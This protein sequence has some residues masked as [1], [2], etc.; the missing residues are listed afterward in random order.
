MIITT[1]LCVDISGMLRLYKRKGSLEGV[2][3]DPET[4]RTLSDAEARQYLQ[5]CLAKGW[6]VLPMGDCDNF[7]HQTGCKG[8][9]KE[10]E[11]N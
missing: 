4:G 1:H 6:R 7:D 10:G 2:I 11:G 3:S 9:P 8:H 5:E